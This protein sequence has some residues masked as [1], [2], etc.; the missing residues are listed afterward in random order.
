MLVINDA[1]GNSP[2][3]QTPRDAESGMFTPNNNSSNL[4][5]WSFCG[6]RVYISRSYRRLLES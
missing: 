6:Q 3:S 1:D 2:P 4:I 5:R